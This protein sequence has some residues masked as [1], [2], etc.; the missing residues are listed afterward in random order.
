M[1]GCEPVP[2]PPFEETVLD[3][4]ASAPVGHHVIDGYQVADHTNPRRDCGTCLGFEAGSLVQAIERHA[5]ELRSRYRMDPHEHFEL[6]EHPGLR[7]EDCVI[8]REHRAHDMLRH[9][10][11]RC[12]GGR[13]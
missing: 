7:H 1:K 3:V 2:C 11:E 10:G 13:R 6:W 9:P 12:D 4:A 5:E 8:T